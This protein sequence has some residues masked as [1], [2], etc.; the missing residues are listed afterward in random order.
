MNYARA[1]THTHSY[2][3]VLSWASIPYSTILT[4]ML[5]R[6]STHSNHRQHTIAHTMKGALAL[7]SLSAKH[8]CLLRSLSPCSKY[9][10]V[11]VHVSVVILSQTSPPPS[12]L[13]PC[14]LIGSQMTQAHTSTGIVKVD[15]FLM[16]SPCT[17]QHKPLERKEECLLATFR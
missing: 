17:A 10:T 9:Q 6:S 16:F 4:T 12:H 7:V 13:N 2:I 3:N 14:E 15:N 5:C 1:H 11:P 8:A